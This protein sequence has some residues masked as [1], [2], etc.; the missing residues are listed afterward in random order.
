VR[1]L[2]SG[3]AP[4]EELGPLWNDHFINVRELRIG[5]LDEETSIDLLVKPIPEFPPDAVPVDI[6]RRIFERTAGQPY[7]LQLFGTLLINR[8]NEENRV[9]ANIDDVPAIE[10]EAL[11]QGRY[12]FGNTY[13][14]A[15]KAVRESLEALALG[16][17]TV[18]A[19]PVRRWLERR[20]LIDEHGALR[21]PVLGEY[22]R[23]ELGA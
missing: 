8:L 1:L 14:D 15:T 12:Y 5:H 3:V 23:Q 7:L 2:V 6:A 22:I 11:S 16:E 13:Q 4:F 17:K 21:T 10:V 19:G 18:V 9:T 20:W